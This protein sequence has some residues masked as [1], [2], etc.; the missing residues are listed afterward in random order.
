MSLLEYSDD[1]PIILRMS[2]VFAFKSIN[3]KSDYRCDGWLVNWYS[4]QF[5][6]CFV[7]SVKDST[8]II[9][10]LQKPFIYK[11]INV[12]IHKSF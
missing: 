6:V 8:I 9:Y 10:C 5:L 7:C 1:K 11:E 12:G 4:I 2:R 3:C